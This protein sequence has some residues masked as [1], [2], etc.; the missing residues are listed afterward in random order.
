MISGRMKEDK[1]RSGEELRSKLCEI[2]NSNAPQRFDNVML[3]KLLDYAHLP[4]DDPRRDPLELKQMFAE[5]DPSLGALK[6]KQRKTMV[7]TLENQVK[8]AQRHNL[9]ERF[10]VEGGWPPKEPEL[11]PPR[12]RPKPSA[13]LIVSPT[14]LYGEGDGFTW[15]QTETELTV[16]VF[17]P[18][19]TQKQEVMMQMTPKFGPAQQL[20]VRARFWPLPLLVGTLHFPVDASEATWHLD[21]GHKV[22]I[23]LPKI[24]EKLW[25]GTPAVFTSGPGPLAEYALPALPGADDATATGAADADAASR[26]AL[27][28]GIAPESIVQ[29]MGQH[30]NDLEVQMQGCKLL[31]TLVETEPGKALGAANA[32]AIQVLLRILR[33]FGHKPEVQISAWRPLLGLVAAQPFLRKFLIDAGGMRLLLGGLDACKANEAVLTQLCLACRSLLPSTPPRPFV[34][35]GGLELLVESLQVC[36]RDRARARHA[37]RR[38]SRPTPRHAPRVITPRRASAAPHDAPHRASPLAAPRPSSVVGRS[39]G[40][41]RG[42]RRPTRRARRSW[43][44]RARASTCSR[45]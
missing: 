20:V 33:T 1:L 35:A 12:A 38:A 36:R 43:R 18:E 2:C 45:E 24:E 37:S 16:T 28:A 31:S 42:R 39:L 34:E 14:P 8:Q 10:F 13:Q 15:T 17:V 32:R 27:V 44:C 41:C 3:N 4:R 19:G 29:K 21:S 40:A 25:P 26:T 7:D 6:L 11:E 30:P 5:I 22:T 9:P 23:D